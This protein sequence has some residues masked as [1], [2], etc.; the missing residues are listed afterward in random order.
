MWKMC[1]T[2][3]HEQSSPDADRIIEILNAIAA[4]RR[5]AADVAQLSDLGRVA[6]LRVG[7]T[8]NRLPVDARRYLVRQMVELAETNLALNF[9]RVLKIAMRDP[10]AEVRARAIAGLWEDES[11]QFVDDLLAAAEVEQDPAVRESIVVA[12]GRFA[13]LAATAELDERR[14]A[15]VRRVLLDSV[16]S[17]EP[18][19]IRRRSLESLSYL[20]SDREVAECIA[21]A[22]GSLIHDMQVSALF[23]MG[24]NLDERW[25]PT[26]LAELGSDDPEVRYE[27][28]KA[29]GEFGDER[30]VEPLLDLLED[31]DREVQ[32]AA[33]GA[34]GQIGGKA[35]TNVLRR[36]SRSDDAPVR[37]AA[38]DALAQALNEA[39]PLRPGTQW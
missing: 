8:W 33:V 30:A 32:L 34:L 5:S 31:E 19:G 22:Y 37:D 38:E 28:A 12:L 15:M 20:S 7:S 29:C 27:A 6:A 17:D 18:V 39:D 35:A 10:D 11:P 3:S 24:R 13:Y 25:L 1:S 36:L 14:S 26:L 21:E 4:G 23:A 16:R 2:T 9:S